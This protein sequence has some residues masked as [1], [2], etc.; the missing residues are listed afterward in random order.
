GNYEIVS[1]ASARYNCMAFANGDERHWWEPG[2]FG[3]RFYWPTNVQQGE[4]LEA[5]QELFIAD[6]YEPT[7]NRDIEPGVEKVAIYVDVVD[8]LPSHV[9]RSDGRSWKSKLGKGQDIEHASLD[10]LEGD[11]MDE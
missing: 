2:L 3:G 5:W 11:R 8:M 10:V 7:D 6:G 9:A 1:R 4:T